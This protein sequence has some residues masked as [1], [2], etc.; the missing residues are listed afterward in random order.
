MI[1]KLECPCETSAMYIAHE[2]PET[3]YKRGTA[4]LLYHM[5]SDDVAHIIELSGSHTV[6]VTDDDRRVLAE[7]FGEL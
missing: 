2:W 7:R 3:T 6:T 5:H 4:V 1:L